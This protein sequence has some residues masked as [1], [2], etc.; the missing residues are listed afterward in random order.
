MYRILVTEHMR[1]YARG[2]A[3]DAKYYELAHG[4]AEQPQRSVWETLEAAGVEVEH[5]PS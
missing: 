3:I 2:M 5:E 1:L 4:A